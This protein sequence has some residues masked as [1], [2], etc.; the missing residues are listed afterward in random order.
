MMW[1]ASGHSWVLI[2]ET[3]ACTHSITPAMMVAIQGKWSA[4]GHGW[5]MIH[6]C[7]D[8]WYKANCWHNYHMQWALALPKTHTHKQHNTHVCVH[9]HTH[10]HRP[11]DHHCNNTNKMKKESTNTMIPVPSPNP[12]NQ[13]LLWGHGSVC[14]YE[15]ICVCKRGWV[16]RVY[17]NIHFQVSPW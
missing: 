3:V 15:N 1:F 11:H 16:G 13:T 9:T 8:G 12:T 5:V 2:H 4:S 17:K 14:V 7:H 6:A 10:A